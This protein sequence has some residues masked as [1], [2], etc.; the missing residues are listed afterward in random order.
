MDKLTYKTN[1]AGL[2]EFY[3]NGSLVTTW[4]YEDDP[5]DSFNEFVKIF[6]AGKQ[7][8]SDSLPALEEALRAVEDTY[9]IQWV[10]DKEYAT[11]TKVKAALNL[12]ESIRDGKES[13]WIKDLPP[14]GCE[15]EVL[16]TQLGNAAYEKCVI[17]YIGSF[18]VVYTSVSCEERYGRI[19]TCNFR[20]LPIKESVDV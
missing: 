6:D 9:E 4:A 3:L 11:M 19:D 17:N 1:D 13:K 5:E 12:C 14:I 15:C 20:P 8:V 16:N 18:V 7:S 2:I 10:S